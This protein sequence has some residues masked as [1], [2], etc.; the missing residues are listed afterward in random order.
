MSPQPTCDRA[1]VIIAHPDDAEFWAGGTIATWTDAGT[2]VAYCVLTD[3]AA[4][5]FDPGVPRTEIPTIRQAEQ[6]AAAD[7]LGVRAI[8]FLSLQ[9]GEVAPSPTLKRVLVRIIRRTRPERVITWYPGWNWARFRTSH[10][11][12]RAT[13]EL[14]LA[15]IYPDAGNRFAH[16][17]LLEDEGL[18]AWQ[19]P[20][21]WLLNSPQP[22]H[23]VDISDVFDR[24]VAAVRAHGS[25][26]G[27]RE[28]LA[29]DLRD[30]IGPNTAAAH[31][32]AGRLAEAFQVV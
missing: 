19:V 7:V 25:Q 1:L 9:E 15:A 17:E 11:N 3:G 31:L 20:E 27:H 10:P 13:G 24:K 23:Y 5:G 6:R 4:G 21:I 8:H 32:P 2:D 26:T 12:H 29:Q 18:E 14:A 22:D 16:P 30:R 28:R